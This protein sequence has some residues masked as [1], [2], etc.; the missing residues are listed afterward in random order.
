MGQLAALDGV[1]ERRGDMFLPDDRP[2]GRGAVFA[3]GISKWGMW[4]RSR[5]LHR[6]GAPLRFKREMTGMRKIIFRDIAL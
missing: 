3:C 1:L 5:R 2:E 4:W 6:I